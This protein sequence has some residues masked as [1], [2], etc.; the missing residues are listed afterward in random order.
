[1]NQDDNDD[2]VSPA[3]TTWMIACGWMQKQNAQAGGGQPSGN[4]EHTFAKHFFSL[5][6]VLQ[7]ANSVENG[8]TGEIIGSTTSKLLNI[9][10]SLY[11]NDFPL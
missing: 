5:K 8:D 3:T 4:L 10:A 11:L 9:T 7:I 1:M 2:Q 6:L